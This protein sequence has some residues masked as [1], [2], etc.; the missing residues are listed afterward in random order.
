MGLNSQE[1]KMEDTEE[2]KAPLEIVCKL[3]QE[4]LKMGLKI[5]DNS[6]EM[7]EQLTKAMKVEE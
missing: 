5:A 4:N 1:G 7:L 2:I 3:I 6:K